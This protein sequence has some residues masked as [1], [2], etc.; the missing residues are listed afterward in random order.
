M[1]VSHL[2]SLHAARLGGGPNGPVTGSKRLA[3]AHDD[4]A[5]TVSGLRGLPARR[6]IQTAGRFAMRIGNRATVVFP[7]TSEAATS[8]T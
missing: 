7:H 3:N 6:V 2:L 5:R 1:H 4:G 8:T